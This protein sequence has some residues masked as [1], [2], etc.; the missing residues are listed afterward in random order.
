MDILWCLV[1]LLKR[2]GTDFW[3]GEGPEFPQIVFDAVKDNPSYSELLLKVKPTGERPWIL[4]WFPEYL[5][6]IR[7]LAV[8]GEVLAKIIDFMCEELQHERFREARPVMMVSAIRVSCS[9]YIVRIYMNKLP[10]I[11]VS[12]SQVSG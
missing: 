6:T 11:V 2:L 7:K 9:A 3:Q 10:V 1:F 5:H 4:A 8:Y 12:T